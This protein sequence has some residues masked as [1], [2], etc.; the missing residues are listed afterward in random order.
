MV[1]VIVQYRLGVLGFLPPLPSG[2]SSG[3]A[4]DEDDPN[5]AISDLVLAL[6]TTKRLAPSLGADGERIT[7]GGQSSGGSLIRGKFGFRFV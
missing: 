6:K 5:V 3:D 1:V 4:G 2:S 7:I